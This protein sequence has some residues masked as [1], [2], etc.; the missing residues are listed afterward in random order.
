MAGC[1]NSAEAAEVLLRAGASVNAGDKKRR[2]AT[3]AASAN[4]CAEC[5]EVLLEHGGD[6]GRGDGCDARRHWCC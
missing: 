6:G 1:A 3:H 5:L 4:D 2:T